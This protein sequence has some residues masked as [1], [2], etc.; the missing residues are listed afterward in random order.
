MSVQL[1]LRD[2]KDD[3]K[4]LFGMSAE[5]VLGVG[6]EPTAYP[7]FRPAAAVNGEASPFVFS[8]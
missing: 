6:H 3:A 5:E 8:L 7:L 2:H 4:P 1:P